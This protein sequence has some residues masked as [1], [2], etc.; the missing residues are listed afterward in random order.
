MGPEMLET[1]APCVLPPRNFQISTE[2]TILTQ[3][4][5]TEDSY[6][7]DRRE[8]EVGELGGK[9]SEGPLGSLLSV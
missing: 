3:R 6:S 7:L 9:G 8:P 2:A 4:N 1:D 5:E